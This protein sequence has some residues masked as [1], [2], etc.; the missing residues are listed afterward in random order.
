MAG[1]PNYPISTAAVSWFDSSNALHIR[2]YSTDGYEV[3]E[4]CNDG[5]GW[6]TGQFNKPGGA[7]SA[8]CWTASDG[9]HIRVYCTYEDK[10]TEWC[11]DPATG[12]TQGTYTP[13]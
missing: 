7:V 2:V 8:I 3:T 10:T 1:N 4:R 13:F 5:Q 11:C 6:Q 9:E 12:W